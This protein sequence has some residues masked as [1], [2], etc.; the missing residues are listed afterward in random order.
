MKI[1]FVPGTL[2]ARIYTI[3][4]IMVFAAIFI[5]QMVFF[6]F[7]MD[8]VRSSTLENNHTLLRQLVVQIDSYISSV[9]RI[10]R[11]IS[12]DR[13]I[14]NFLENDGFVDPGETEQIRKSLNNY[15]KAREDISDILIVYHDGTVLSGELEA[16][17]NPWVS[18]LDMDWFRGALE[19]NGQT[20]V[21]SS[22]VQNIMAG[23]YTWVVS[24]S[25][26]IISEWTGE[27][28]GVLLVDLK[29]NR[30]EELCRSLVVGAKGY[31]FILDRDGN[32]VFH[33][34]Q[35]LV[36]SN[37][38]TEPVG[39][40]LALLG[41][42]QG[43]AF[44][45]GDRYFM[46]ETSGLT[47][48]H[49][50]GVSHDSDM[51]TD[52][53][54][55]QITY[56]F[57]G[58]I[59]FLVVGLAT[60]RISSGITKPMHRLQDIMKTV[61]KGEFHLVG[62]IKATEE[63]RELARDYDIMVGRIRELVAANTREQELKRKSDLKALQAQINPHFLYNTL[64]SIIWMGEMGQNREVVKMTSAL[65]KLFRISISKGQEIITIRDEVAHVQSYLTIQGMRYQDK[66]T[67]LI[68]IDPELH[69]YPILK[70]TLQPL[71]ENAIYHGIKESEGKGFIHISGYAR[72]ENIIITVKDNGA[73]MTP[74]ELEDLI[75]GIETAPENRP[76]LSRQGM[77]LR[78]V[79]Q[80]IRLYF[81]P[82]Y[83]LSCESSL[84]SG[85]IMTIR[86]PLKEWEA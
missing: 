60:N 50:V 7:T 57:I 6:R 36:Y 43:R 28:L 73:G 48:W 67:Y 32:Y 29:F 19:R 24:L 58:L 54:Y 71:V 21:S 13:D 42:H 33:P 76:K 46:V 40:I 12:G 25:R 81:G 34:T 56:G 70:I 53:K 55:V 65:S 75:S 84:S 14:Q 4:T 41:S 10:T 37:L 17:V 86:L 18:V 27:S 85:T 20:Y 2:E 79:H 51:I 45:E 3:F 63:I 80:R 78:N 39:E 35:Q 38:R 77:G 8:T 1:N 47:D 64:D 72:D 23:R 5:M 11:S 66:F 31:D 68:D 9:E 26:E 30:I 82:Q 49:I 15:I 83:G 44:K 62:E 61:E 22:Y 74:M 59:L 52:W 69:D 16:E